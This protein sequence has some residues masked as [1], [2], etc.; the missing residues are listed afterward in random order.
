MPSNQLRIQLPKF[1]ASEKSEKAEIF[2]D[3]QGVIDLD[4]PVSSKSGSIKK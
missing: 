3:A 4:A 1:I 2:V